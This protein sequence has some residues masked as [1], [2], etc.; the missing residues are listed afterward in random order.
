M[1]R[2][3]DAGTLR[4]R[5]RLAVME[6]ECTWADAGRA[7]ARIV[8]KWSTGAMTHA[9][10]LWLVIAALGERK[11]LFRSQPAEGKN[12]VPLRRAAP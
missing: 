10:A 5:Q 3:P 7:T 8:D 4:P 11:L 9:D 12:V 2:A 6:N 1:K